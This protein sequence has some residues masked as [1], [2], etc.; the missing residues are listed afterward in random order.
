[1]KTKV[2]G[3]AITSETVS[4]NTVSGE[5]EKPV[6]E[7]APEI[8]KKV[9][10][11]PN[12]DKK[13]IENKSIR[14]PNY[15]S[16]SSNKGEMEIQQTSKDLNCAREVYYDLIQMQRMART[17]HTTKKVVREDRTPPKEVSGKCQEKLRNQRKE[18]TGFGLA[19]RP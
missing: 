15:L 12:K 3:T 10:R 11:V 1:M 9:P 19:Q 5:M 4:Q 7:R 17:K 16:E 14:K 2:I 8:A 18:Y 6:T 13:Q